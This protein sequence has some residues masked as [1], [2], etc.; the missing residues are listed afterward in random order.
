MEHGLE[1]ITFYVQKYI[2]PFVVFPAAALVRDGPL[3]APTF[4]RLAYVL[5][6]SPGTTRMG[7]IGGHLQHKKA[8][9]PV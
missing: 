1:Y 2:A 5:H 3:G 8:F 7:V 4:L 6:K 9:L